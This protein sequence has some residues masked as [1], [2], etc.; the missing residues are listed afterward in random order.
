[1]YDIFIEK[2]VSQ[3]EVNLSNRNNT[4][5]LDQNYAHKHL[6]RRYL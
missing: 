5:Y 1:M 4:S 2:K 3:L 6:N